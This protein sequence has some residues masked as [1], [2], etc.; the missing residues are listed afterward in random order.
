MSNFVMRKRVLSG[1]DA[2]SAS[3]MTPAMFAHVG[4]KSKDEKKRS[5]FRLATKIPKTALLG[6]LVFVVLVSLLTVIYNFTETPLGESTQ[7]ADK[8]IKSQ[9]INPTLRRPDL[10]ESSPEQ[11]ITD[12]P[13]PKPAVT[14]PNVLLIEAGTSVVRIHPAFH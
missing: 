2:A 10:M 11:K 7:T 4:D 9:N 14:L 6:S 12:R 13:S 1:K 3:A 8:T 5:A